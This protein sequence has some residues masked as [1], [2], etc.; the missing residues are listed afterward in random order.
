VGPALDLARPHRQQGH[1]AVERLS[2]RFLVHTQDHGFLWRVHIEP[3]DV[4]HLL[5]E[6]RV[7]GQLE[8]LGPMGLERERSPDPT[9]RALAHAGPLGHRPGTPM[10][11]ADRGALQG[12]GHDPIHVRIG[13]LPWRSWTWL[14]EQ[15]VEAPL[16]EP[17]A[18]F[19]DH[20]FG[21]P[22]F[23]GHDGIGFAFRAGHNQTRPL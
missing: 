19:A 21:H 6:Q 8:G 16:T 12:Q 1:G 10:R 13:D 11:R 5:D 17:G 9:D 7:F 2:L 4:A 20:L 18:P 14:V 15:P 3:D 22:E 23:S